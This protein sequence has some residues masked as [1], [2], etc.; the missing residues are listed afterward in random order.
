[1]QS[2]SGPIPGQSLTTEP[3]GYPWERPPEIVDPEEA[4][5]M[6]I[7]RLSDPE[8]LGDVL[9]ILEFEEVD[10]QTLVVGMMRGAVANGIHSID[11]GMMVAPV[12]HEFIKQAAKAA[13][14][15]AEDGFEDKK[16]NKEKE[17]YRI[18]SRAR[19]MLKEMGAKPKEVVKEIEM[20][21]SSEE[22]EEG[23]SV[24]PRGLMARGDM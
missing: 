20:E 18:N 8:M 4:I 13:G 17:Q 5:Q 24:A 22:G 9:D 7:V 11:V 6:H 19:K 12:V 15:D 10:I 2:L 3:K 1:M 23:I 14:I 21:E 16:A